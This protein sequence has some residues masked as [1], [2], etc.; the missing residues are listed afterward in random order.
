MS[1]E[2]K[3]LGSGCKNCMALE[4]NAKAAVAA[5]GLS[6]QVTKV[7]EMADIMAYGIMR[8]PGLVVNEQVKVFGRVP[9]VD[10]IKTLL[11]G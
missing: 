11:K 6:A 5:L 10:E 2:I 4:A 8:T 7:T 9:P 1:M 3:I